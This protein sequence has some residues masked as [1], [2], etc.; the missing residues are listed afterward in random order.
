MWFPADASRTKTAILRP[1][2]IAVAVQLAITGATTAVRLRAGRDDT[3]IYFR[4]ATL[5]L[6]GKVPYRDF[7]VEYPPLALPLFL[8]AALASHDVTGFKIAFAVEMLIFNAATVWL[9]A[10]WVDQSHGR[11]HVRIRLVWYTLL[12]LLLSRLL[13]SRYDAATMFLG[14]AASIWWFSRR[15]GRGGLAT[16]LGTLMKVYPAVIAMVAI[17]WDLTRPGPSRGRGL[18]AFI[19]ALSLGSL[20]WLATAGPHGVAE[21]LRYQLGRG[22][23]YGSLYSGVQMLAAKAVGAEIAVVRDHAAWA[24]VTP[25]SS[26]LLTLVLPIQATSILAV[27]AVFFRRGMSEGVRYSGAAILAFII[28]GK[29]FSPQYL[30]WLLPF[31]AV[32]EGPIARR[33]FWLFAAGCAATLIAPALTSSF[34]RTGVVVILAYNIKNALFLAILA[35]LTLGPGSD[36]AGGRPGTRPDEKSAR[37]QR[38]ELPGYYPTRRS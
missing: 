16:A 38:I 35:I 7:R 8:A 17:P 2:V 4:Y 11:N 18:A 37:R 32:L 5:M 10:D 25:W 15:R 12:Y 22:F 28:A 14:F 19:A 27:C 23:E 33:S 30:I 3:D 1:V 21:S 20:A 9:V 31:I 13:V 36:D 34:P 29:V 24:S 6:E 26:R